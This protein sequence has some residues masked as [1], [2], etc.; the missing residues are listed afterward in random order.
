MALKHGW[1]HDEAQR[2]FILDKMPRTNK[3]TVCPPTGELVGCL[4][5][6]VVTCNFMTAR[7]RADQAEQSRR[8]SSATCNSYVLTLKC[9]DQSWTRVKDQEKLSSNQ[10]GIYHCPCYWYPAANPSPTRFAGSSVKPMSEALNVV[11]NL[12]FTR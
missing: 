9:Q 6:S 12:N 3:L 8:A 1:L 11:Q 4:V 5:I 10:E 7:K 2:K